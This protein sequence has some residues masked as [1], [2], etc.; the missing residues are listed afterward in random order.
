MIRRKVATDNTD[1]YWI[2]HVFYT[3]IEDEQN[4][5]NKFNITVYDMQTIKKKTYMKVC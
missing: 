3:E 5:R 2:S 1:R 4:F